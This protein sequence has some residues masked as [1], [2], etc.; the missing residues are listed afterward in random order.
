M[1]SGF[2]CRVYDKASRYLREST[3]RAHL[4]LDASSNE[5]PTREGCGCMSFGPK[6]SDGQTKKEMS[7]DVNFR[8]ATKNP[9][10]PTW[11]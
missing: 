11:W 7:I 5:V 10:N 3:G 6:N 1:P 8:V 9:S 4:G 2:F